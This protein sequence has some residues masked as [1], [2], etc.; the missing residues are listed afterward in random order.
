MED[1]MISEVTNCYENKSEN[2]IQ[3]LREIHKKQNYITPTQLEEVAQKLNLPLSKVYGAV[4]FYTLLSPKPKGK[5]V[6][7][8]CS[9]TPCY[10]AGSENL[11]KYLKDK[12]KIQEGETSADG[13]FTLESTSCLGICAVA[14]AIMVNDRVYGDLNIQKLDQIIERRK[15]GKIEK[16]KFVSLRANILSNKEGRI[17][18]QNCGI[19]N[20]ESIEEYK[21]RNGYAAL[22]KA[23]IK[24]TPQEVIKEVKDSKLVGRG[25][26]AFPTGLK[27]E[28]T[29][30][31]ADKP[32]YIVCN[33]DE[34]EPGTF[35][36]R[37]ILEND[38]HKIVEAMVIAGYAVGAEYGY[39]Y[40]RGE[41][42]L[43][44]KRIKQAI[45]M[46]KEQNY[47]GK[48]ILGT[49]FSFNLVIRE[50]AGA[51]ICGDET[52]LMESIEGKRGEPRLKPPYPPTSGLWNKPTV[53]NNVET[54]ANIPSIILKGADWYN[55]IGLAESTGTKVLT[56]LGDIKNQG[57][58]E[59][60]L[61]TN[62]KDILYDIGG[63]IK[64]GKKLKMVQL[65]GPSGSY[66]SPDMIDISLDYKVLSQ[67]G[68]TLG[69][70]VVLVLCEDRCVVDIVRNIARFFQHESCGKCTP[71]REGTAIIYQILTKIALGKGENNDLETLK[72]LGEIMKDA[73]FCGLGQTAP[74]SLLNTLQLFPE[75]YREHIQKKGC[76]LNVC[77]E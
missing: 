72:L 57:A 75:E 38:P 40:I 25:G 36:D 30:R 65:G 1:L 20:P 67:A 17:V 28:F 11:L 58:V 49:K 64:E 7:R 14:P 66:L 10:M 42:N 23:I 34:G 8:I 29:F 19:I 43:S 18:L 12:L 13:L 61:G 21:M 63:G 73:S 6:L 33:A 26:A 9:S 70:G 5:Y 51:Y 47:L 69:S 48:N 55:K 24:M 39:I 37:L 71:C 62:L 4:T 50:G 76:P 52:A 44:I 2:L 16:E 45:E 60:P 74:N 46:A 22:S 27:W 53:I 59:V 32:K 31:A 68:L 15:R 41:Y 77:R 54:L 35:K 3:I 56:L